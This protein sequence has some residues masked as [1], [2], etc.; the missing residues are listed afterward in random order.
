MFGTK[1]KGKTPSDFRMEIDDHASALKML[2]FVRS[3]WSL[4]DGTAD[5]PELD[6][7]PD[8]G[9]SS[10]PGTAD[11]GTWVQRWNH[12]WQRAWSWYQLKEDQAAPL[13]QVV[14]QDLSRSGRELHPFVPPFWN[15]EYGIDG[16]D[17]SAFQEWD[18]LTLPKFPPQPESREIVSAM[19][20]AWERGLTRIIVLPYRGHF[21]AVV[22]AG[23]LVIS[24]RT[25]NAPDQFKAALQIFP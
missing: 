15:I 18:Q 24:A 5:L 3:A 21:A 4:E 23:Q 20:A 11:R 17:M 25:R 7:I 14:M 22:N 16:F 10:L 9:I 13:S 19:A 6:P 2:L 12:E 1:R 8:A